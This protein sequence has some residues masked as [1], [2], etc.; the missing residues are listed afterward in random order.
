MSSGTLVLGRRGQARQEGWWTRSS[1]EWR[2]EVHIVMIEYWVCRV[3]KAWSAK[4]EGRVKS[5]DNRTGQERAR[6]RQRL[7][8]CAS[9]LLR[10]SLSF[11]AHF[12]SRHPSPCLSSNSTMGNK[13]TVCLLTRDQIIDYVESTHCKSSMNGCIMDIVLHLACFAA[14]VFAL[15]CCRVVIVDCVV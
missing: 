4:R 13:H 15:L 2:A 7:L 8:V 1:E 3:K 14:P 9:P 6:G 10:F 12:T 11:S 5:E